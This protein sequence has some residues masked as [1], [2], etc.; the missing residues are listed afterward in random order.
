[1][2][3]YSI[4]NGAGSSSHGFTSLPSTSTILERAPAAF[5]NSLPKYTAVTAPALLTTKP[6]KSSKARTCLCQ[7]KQLSKERAVDHSAFDI[8][9]TDSRPPM[10]DVT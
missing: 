3:Y 2:S 5:E 7:P 6:L 8:G 4:L 9:G 1:M 10:T